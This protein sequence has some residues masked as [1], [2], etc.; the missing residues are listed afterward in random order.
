MIRG[1]YTSGQ[2]M[3]T[4]MQTLEV[5]SNNIA[6]AN[7]TGFR[8]ATAVQQS[9]PELLMNT[10]DTMPGSMPHNIDPAG[11]VSLGTLIVEHNVN[12]SQGALQQTGGSLDLAIGGG[13]FFA[14]EH[15][16]GSEMYT[17][18]GAFTLDANRFLVTGGGDRVL[19]A[20]GNHIMIPDDG[21]IIIGANGEI[22]V[23]GNLVDTLRLVDFEN[24]AELR[25]FGY[26]LFT[27]LPE[28]GLTEFSGTL[29]QGYLE[30]SNVNIVNEMVRMINVSRAF[31]LNQRMVG[32]QDQTLA[33]AVSEIAR[34]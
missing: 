6:N 3:M 22:R 11:R 20:A 33:Q 24:L 32:M 14:V 2:G 28:A 10:M 1:M 26:N 5:I 21:E 23:D 17:R 31:E 29:A 8:G 25:Q 16:N 13:G 4:Q 18:N 19:G 27:A 7:T 34:R 9:F 12:F 15:S 30:R